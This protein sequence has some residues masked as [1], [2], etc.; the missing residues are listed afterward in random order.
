ML[1]L[2]I[3]QP[4]GLWRRAKEDHTIPREH[5]GPIFVPK[6]AHIFANFNRAHNNVRTFLAL[7]SY[8]L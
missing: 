4:L 2:G 5:G 7:S 8:N 1:C 3:G 6:D